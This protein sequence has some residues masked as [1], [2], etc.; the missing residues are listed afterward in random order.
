MAF[1]SGY[2]DKNYKPKP[3]DLVCTFKVRPAS[4]ASIEEA[5]GAV[6]GESSVGTWT[7]VLTSSPRIRAMGAKVFSINGHVIK[8]AYPFELFEPG[9]MAQIF[10]SIAGNIF[11]MKILETLRLED[12]HWPEKFASSFPGPK[13]GIKGIRKLL[14]VPKRPLCGTI[15][16]PKLGLSE[17]EHAKVAYEAWSGGLDIVKDDENL[18]NQ[19]FNKFDERITETLKLR[20]KAERETGEKKIYMPNVSAEYNEMLRRA[21]FVKKCGGEYVMVD[22]LTVG[23]SALQALRNEN[24]GLVI[25]AHRAMHAALTRNTEHGISMLVLADAAK[26]CGVDQLHIGTAVGKMEGPKEEVVELS[27]R[28]KPVFP[29]CSGGLHPGHVPELVRMLGNDIIIQAGGGV[30]GH[31]GG[32]VK[33]AMAM[34]QMIDSVMEG[35]PPREYARKHRELA[36]AIEKWGVLSRT[37][38]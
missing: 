34:R 36:L 35:I 12:V 18:T 32:T 31:P 17:K 6:A 19:L 33:G 29:V 24:L 2:V 25:H 10:S 9:N 15:I 7:D 26:L 27:K 13:F 28:I 30:H 11:G 1:Y 38:N 23:W 22:I 20:D 16:K 8:V 14:R 37:A 5:A 4:G 3:T 21:K